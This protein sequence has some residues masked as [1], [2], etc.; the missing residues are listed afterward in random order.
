MSQSWYA[1]HSKPNKE[2]FLY[3]QLMHRNLDVYYPR[4][5]VT[6][7]NPRS[8]KVKPLFPG[9]L[10]IHVDL[11]KVPVSTLAYVPGAHSV[12]SF[13]YQPATIPDEVIDGIKK[14]VSLI[15]QQQQKAKQGLKHGDPVIIQGGPFDGYQAIFDTSLPGSERV[16]VLISLM[17]DRQVRIQVPDEMVKPK[18]Q[19]R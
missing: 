11:D 17:R 19:K 2:E 13:D 4:L 3:S 12:V 6:P 14:N 18:K 9:Y 1:L 8:R 5:S 15:N 7:V 16:R 10:F